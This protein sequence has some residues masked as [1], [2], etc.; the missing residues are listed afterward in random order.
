MSIFSSAVRR[1]IFPF[2]Q[3]TRLRARQQEALEVFDL[4]TEAMGE[5]ERRREPRNPVLES[6]LKQLDD[7]IRCHD[8]DIAFFQSKHRGVAALLARLG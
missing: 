6:V 8:A 5:L 4:L 2:E 1:A 7:R 3:V